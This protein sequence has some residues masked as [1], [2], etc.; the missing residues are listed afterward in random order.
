MK[1]PSKYINEIYNYEGKWGIPSFC[2]IKIIKKTSRTIVIATE[3]YETNPGTS[4]TN[5]TGELANDMCIKEGI[6]PAEIIFIVHN[7][8]KKSK[9]EFYKETF[10]IVKFDK[11]E[12]VL[13]NPQWKRVSMEKVD[14]MIKDD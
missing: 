6:D 7:P 9:L 3:M 11:D 12:E 14:E 10:D 13:K 5:F 1:I 8:D 4:V 2:G